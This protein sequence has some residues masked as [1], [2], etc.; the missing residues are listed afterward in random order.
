MWKEILDY[1]RKLIS[2]QRAVDTHDADIK[3]IRAE[4][5]QNTI[6]LQALSQLVREY[7]HEQ[8]KDRALMEKDRAAAEK[9][10]E[11][12]MLRLE[13]LLLRSE[14]ALPPGKQPDE[15]Q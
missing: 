4:L 1:G 2:I 3:D 12:L 6:E 15:S 10:R 5:K 7:R 8:E 13:N 14:R 11:I 9:D